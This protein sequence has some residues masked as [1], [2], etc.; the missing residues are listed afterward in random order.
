MRL[1]GGAVTAIAPH[2]ERAGYHTIEAP[3]G[4][5]FTVVCR[6]LREDP[7]EYYDHIRRCLRNSRLRGGT[8]TS[9]SGRYGLSPYSLLE[10][11]NTFAIQRLGV[12]AVWV[13]DCLFDM[14]EME[15]RARVVHTAGGEV[16][17]SVMY[18]ISPVHTDEWFAERVRT[19]VSWGVASAIYVEDAPGILTPERTK[20]LIPAIIEAAQGLPVELHCHNTTG[21][22]PLNYLIAADLGV[23]VLHTCSRP[24]A[25]GPSL[26]SIEM[27]LPNLESAGHTHSINKSTLAPVAEHMER[28]ARQEGQ[29]LGVPNEYDRR[30]YDHQL[31]G[32]M[33]GSFKAQLAQHGMEDKLDAVLEE[34]PQ[35]REELG[36][37]VSATP[38]SQFIGTQAVLNVVSGERYSITIDEIA[39]FVQGLYGPPASPINQDVKDRV[40]STPR[41]KELTGYQRPDMTLDE[42]RKEYGGSH[43]S[44]D[45]LFR[46]NYAP[47]SDIEAT[48]AAGPLRTEYRFVPTLSELIKQAVETKRA[49]HV[50]IRT[51]KFSL[52]V[53]HH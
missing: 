8:R 30:A 19:M 16:I 23:S 34:I 26:P 15:R 43:I 52:E 39:M 12:N 42:V 28:V 18:G 2:L 41:G 49:R 48:R 11:L 32:G 10:F 38:F 29:P 51:P 13:Y 46:L 36:H 20:T 45:D 22:A 40:L 5:F 9:S 31:P 33:M 53:V 21:L 25:N 50:R 14:V 1:P 7:I 4:S 44:D 6:Y 37:P 27:M 35:V 3:S 47:P 24:V 17:P